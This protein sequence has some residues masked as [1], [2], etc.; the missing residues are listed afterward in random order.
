MR[1]L[2]VLQAWLAG[3][4]LLAL[5]VVG[6]TL[7]ASDGAALAA[8]LQ[9]PVLIGAAVA[10][11]Q[12]YQRQRHLLDQQQ[13]ELATLRPL[14][15]D[16]PVAVVALDL[17]GCVTVWNGAAERV[18]GW[19]EAE[20]IGRPL[21]H[22]PPAKRHEA[23]ALQHQVKTGLP[24]HNLPLS[25]L[26]KT[27]TPLHLSVSCTP[28]RDFGSN[29]V[30]LMALY[31][32]PADAESPAPG[33]VD[34]PFRGLIE[35]SL[36]GLYIIQDEIFQYVNARYA[37]MYG[38]SPQ[39]MI[40][41]PAA[42]FLDA[43]DRARFYENMRRRISGETASIRYYLRGRHRDG[44]IVDMEAHGT[45]YEYRGRPAVIGIQL[46]VT[47]RLQFE[48]ELRES[49]AR[50]KAMTANVPGVVYQLVRPAGGE[51]R[52]SYVSQGITALCGLEPQVLLTDA[53]RF[54]E[55]LLPEDGKALRQALEESGRS[56]ADLNW[57]GRLRSLGGELVWANARAR[58]RAGDDGAILWD[59]LLFNISA[60]KRQEE[61]IRTSREQMRELSVYINNVREEQ[62]T[63][64][65]RE[66]HDVLGGTLTTLLM[67]LEWLARQVSAPKA[68]ARAGAMI[69]LA[70]E[71]IETVQKISAD[72]RPGVLD[73]LGLLAA[74]EW[75]CHQLRSRMGIECALSLAP[76]PVELPER[77][78]TAIFRIF[79]ETLTNIARH[80]G[81]THVD[82]LVGVEHGM[83]EITVEDNGSGI[84][85]EQMAARHAFGI[86]G[87]FERA[88]EI[89]ATLQIEGTPGRGTRTV[90]DYPLP[91][92]Q[93]MTGSH[94]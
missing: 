11:Q 81:A 87:M 75:Q 22:V 78:A 40:G 36:A 57:E 37:Q 44:H 80:A 33:P 13:E 42:D 12:H 51:V 85:R 65:A 48:R 82:V 56:L 55:L 52:F 7:M 28:L 74:I 23:Q 41:R 34:V 17:D 21:P 91:A 66:I 20:V 18:F 15:R 86:M 64:I 35:Q 43:P 72:L 32:D 9:L 45:R 90:L 60:A 39:E 1:E 92:A 49:E 2:R 50:L 24:F 94:D 14:I 46:D 27:G 71:A 59:G 38:Y 19:R 76:H 84:S 26:T 25:R 79:Q 63:K 73:N 88:R 58:P 68:V 8:L 77:E 62:R 89:G 70:Q 6:L 61:E 54:T 31:Q 83:L 3:A 4:A 47:E 5:G 16:V 67:D 93:R 29:I 53:R 10:A 30:G 69:D